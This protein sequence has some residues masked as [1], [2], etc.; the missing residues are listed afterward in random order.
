MRALDLAVFYD[1]VHYSFYA[2]E[3]EQ[4]CFSAVRAEKAE[5]IQDLQGREG[6][7]R[8]LLAFL[9]SSALLRSDATAVLTLGRL[10]PS[11]ASGQKPPQGVQAGW[12]RWG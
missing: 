10:L 7:K 2:V 9:S 1:L 4:T 11:A 6:L 8:L 12:L 5:L 3:T